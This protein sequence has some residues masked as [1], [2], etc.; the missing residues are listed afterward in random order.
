MATIQPND[1]HQTLPT[2]VNSPALTHLPKNQHLAAENPSPRGARIQM[3][4]RIG[5]F[6]PTRLFIPTLGIATDPGIANASQ[7]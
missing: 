2:P 7:H 5:T 6:F 3:R 4:G 1:D